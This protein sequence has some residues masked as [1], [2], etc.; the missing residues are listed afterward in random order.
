[1]S[2]S[3]FSVV[4]PQQYVRMRS[5]FVARTEWCS[6]VFWLCESVP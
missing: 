3:P 5:I 6:Q 1:M 2:A 4:A